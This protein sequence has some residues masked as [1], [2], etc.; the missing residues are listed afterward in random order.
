[1][2]KVELID[3]NGKIT[4]TSVRTIARIVVQKIK[5]SGKHN[6]IQFG[7]KIGLY[8]LKKKSIFQKPNIIAKCIYV[9]VDA[10]L[11]SNNDLLYYLH[12]FFCAIFCIIL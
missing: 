11:Y 2:Y 3:N 8:C 1:M 7:F 12:N 6:L 4:T 5:E 9:Y 10:F